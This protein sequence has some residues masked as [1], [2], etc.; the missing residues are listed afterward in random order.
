MAI[1]G[2][3]VAYNRVLLLGPAAINPVTCKI[4]LNAGAFVVPS[5]PVMSPVGNG[6][7]VF[8]LNAS[9]LPI[10]GDLAYLV[11]DGLGNTYT[12][13][14][15]QVVTGDPGNCVGFVP[16]D[17]TGQVQLQLIA[18]INNAT[19]AVT[20]QGA[21]NGLSIVG[22]TGNAINLTANSPCIQATSFGT[23]C[24]QINSDNGN[25]IT[26]VGS[27]SGLF[28][29]T[30]STG[31][32]CE[33]YSPSGIGL[34]IVGDYDGL[35]IVGAT[36]AAIELAGGP[37][38]DIGCDGSGFI[39]NITGHVNDVILA[40]FQ[41]FLSPAIAGDQMDLV[42]DPNAT[43]LTAIATAVL[44]LPN[45][46]EFGVTPTQALSVILAACSG[47]GGPVGSVCTYYDPTGT[48]ARLSGTVSMSGVRTGMAIIP[49]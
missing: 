23:D 39:G 5:V 38:G 19:D 20:L 16:N 31:A 43:A 12:F 35:Y 22:G 8:I 4:S 26:L 6:Y 18:V 33:I 32:A 24:V 1:L 21:G 37:A 28:I 10:P 45:G 40:G 42:N 47:N 29:T 17:G 9:D 27:D 49:F 41:P 36:N 48:N 30:S 3:N 15:D 46:A 7:W 34:Q 11:T 13:V 14:T 2:Q 44:G 25:G